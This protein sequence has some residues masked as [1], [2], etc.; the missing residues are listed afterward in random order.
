MT[1]RAEIGYPVLHRPFSSRSDLIERIRR[2]ATASKLGARREDEAELT[3]AAADTLALLA[4]ILNALD[5]NAT[6]HPES[7]KGHFFISGDVTLDERQRVIYRGDERADISPLEY[8][9]FL[10]LAHHDGAAVSKQTLLKEVWNDRVQSSS[11]T[12][13][14]HILELRKKLESDPRNPQCI[15]TVRKFGYRVVGRWAARPR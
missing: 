8:E 6:V 15:L 14:Q 4:E 9:L 5:R 11:R 13:D 1:F 7:G 2:Q 12:I 10:T 3:A